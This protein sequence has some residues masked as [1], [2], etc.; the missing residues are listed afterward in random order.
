MA[1]SS[2]RKFFIV[3]LILGIIGSIG[4]LAIIYHELDNLLLKKISCKIFDKHQLH[5]TTSDQLDPDD[6]TI[7][8]HTLDADKTIY[9]NGKPKGRIPY[10]K[11]PDYCFDVFYKDSLIG[12][13]GHV[14][15]RWYHTNNY[16]FRIT[17]PADKFHLTFEVNG[18]DATSAKY[19]NQLIHKSS[20]AKNS[21][22]TNEIIVSNQKAAK[23]NI[24]KLKIEDDDFQKIKA[25]TGE[26]LSF[27]NPKVNINDKKMKTKKVKIFGQ[28][29]LKYKRKNYNISLDKAYKFKEGDRPYKLKKFKLVSLSMDYYYFHNY[30]SYSLLKE[31]GLFDLY[32]TYT[33]LIINGQS[34]G[35][36]LLVE[37]PKRTMM[38]KFD[39]DFHIRR[40]FENSSFP[41]R[42]PWDGEPYEYKNSRHTLETYLASFNS[43]YKNIKNESDKTVLDSLEGVLNLES[44]LKWM[45]IN[46]LLCNGDCTDEIYLYACPEKE[47]PY[48]NILPWDFDDSFAPQPH[49]GWEER[50]AAIGDKAIFSI[51]DSLNLEIAQNPLLYELYLNQL[52]ADL[53]VIDERLILNTF[54]KAY[55][56]LHPY[57][58]DQAILEMTEHDEYG[59]LT[60]EDLKSTINAYCDYLITRR[61]NT[62]TNYELSHR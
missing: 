37:D 36:Y 34:Q 51:E 60:E 57:F 40:G 16:T 46:Y 38:K 22:M 8:W 5:V 53:R 55:N 47:N 39:S 19:W 14:I 27:S 35:V 1:R 9:E 58:Q 62:I 45:G 44:Y 56:E 26:K 20:I 59:V 52:S 4:A 11:S 32:F 41:G 2:L 42:P 33:E 13:V 49:E 7:R 10:L 28:S 48:F 18:P 15:K 61:K 43:I 30:V 50:H 24:I 31:L 3:I 17:K 54:S 21:A 25:N 23:K 6:I 12:Q 29:S